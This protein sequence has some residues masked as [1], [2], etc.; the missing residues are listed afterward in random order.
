ML[1]DVYCKGDHWL[2]IYAYG[3]DIP[4][5]SQWINKKRTFVGRQ[6]CVFCCERA[7]KRCIKVGK[8][9][10]K[11]CDFALLTTRQIGICFL[12]QFSFFVYVLMILVRQIMIMLVFMLYCIRMS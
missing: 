6:K 5:L 1:K 10:K 3:D 4:L 7:V 2:M 9:S 8:N 12:T 11:V